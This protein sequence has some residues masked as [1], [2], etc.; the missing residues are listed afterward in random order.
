MCRK[1]NEIFNTVIVMNL[2]SYVSCQEIIVYM[3]NENIY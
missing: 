1:R 3:S 2:H